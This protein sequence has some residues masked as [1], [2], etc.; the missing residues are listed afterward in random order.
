MSLSK[1]KNIVLVLSGKGGVGKSSVT[2]Q[3]ALSLSLAGHSVG[4]LDIDLTGP[5]IPHMFRVADQGR[6]TQGPDGWLPV[7]IHDAGPTKGRGSLRVMSLGFLVRPGDSVVWRGPKKTAMIKQFLTDVAWGETD[8]LLID[9]PPGT[10]DEHISAVEY[11]LQFARP[12]QLAGAVLVTTPQAVA[13]ADVRKELDFC[14]KTGIRII[15]IVENM[16]GFVC[17]NCSECTYLFSKGGGQVLAQDFGVEFLGS[18]PID[19]QF[20]V[21]ISKGR[22]PTYPEG[23]V[24]LGQNIESLAS[25]YQYCSLCPVYRSITESVVRIVGTTG[26]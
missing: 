5:N 4:V 19:P 18:V 20:S 6:I 21:M 17:P 26:S 10:S 3:L 13:T 12:D 2:T 25:M 24:L 16:S 7:E 9:T 14:Q 15:G 1:I 22:R 23:T 11:L 8:F